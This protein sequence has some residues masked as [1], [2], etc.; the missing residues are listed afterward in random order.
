MMNNDN[1]NKEEFEDIISENTDT[2]A[3]EPELEEIEAVGENKLKSLRTKLKQAEEDKRDA[4]EELAIAKADFLN[5]RK[6][7]EEESARKV[8]RNT[9]R[10]VE[11]LL[12]LY[13]SFHMAMSNTT[14]WEKADENWRK[15]IEGI[16]AQLKQILDDHKVTAVIPTGEEFD[17]NT[18]DAIGTEPASPDLIDKVISVMQHGFTMEVNGKTENIRPARVTT[19]TAKETP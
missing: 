13:D 14:V 9:I 4:L 6:R 10:H 1:E 2:A 3:E 16:H 5:A 15:G 18:H 7:L 11:A 12:P 17:P 19:G 8:E